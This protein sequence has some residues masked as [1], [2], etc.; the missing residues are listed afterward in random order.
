MVD[1]SQHSYSEAEVEQAIDELEPK[2]RLDGIE[3]ESELTQLL[4]YGVLLR[5]A[6]ESIL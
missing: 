3:L 6:K 5:E 2:V 1:T 4:S